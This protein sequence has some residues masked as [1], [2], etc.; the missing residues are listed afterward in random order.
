MYSVSKERHLSNRDGKL[1]AHT[2]NE[3]RELQS[4]FEGNTLR[5]RYHVIDKFGQRSFY[6][7]SN[8]EQA[9]R[10][11]RNEI[12]LNSKYIS[13]KEIN[14]LKDNDFIS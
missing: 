11:L 9:L 14:S 8:K 1:L 4:L 2:A 6:T 3:A 7:F 12:K 5:T 10:E 13:L